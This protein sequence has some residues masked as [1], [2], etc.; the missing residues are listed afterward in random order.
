MEVNTVLDALRAVT[1]R[2]EPE[3]KSNELNRDTFLRLFI[4]QL[5]NQNPLNPATS[6]EF[7]AQLA[8]F[9]ALEQ[10]T[11]TATL[12]QEL[13]DQGKQRERVDL[14][15]F[16]GHDVTAV[17]DTIQVTDAT[18]TSL[19]YDLQSEASTV[20]VVISDALGN[21]VR[22]L[23]FGPQA[24]G[25]HVVDW[26]GLDDQGSPVPLGTYRFEVQAVGP[27]GLAVATTTFLREKV[28]SVSWE[29]DQAEL[30]LASGRSLLASDVVSILGP[31]E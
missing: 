26:D 18:S 31:R 12:I 11:K 24:A 28:V 1:E 8:Q 29:A 9:T 19:T 15:N 30:L 25:R 21:E 2:P 17:G 13:I 14:I 10:T 6:E 27:D 5:Q 20:A 22:T 4:T 16:I 23:Q 3:S 7:V